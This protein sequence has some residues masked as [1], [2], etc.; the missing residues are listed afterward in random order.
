MEESVLQTAVVVM[1]DNAA[2]TK[3]WSSLE[4][5]SMIISAPS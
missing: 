1:V 5:T 4:V 3:K 2:L